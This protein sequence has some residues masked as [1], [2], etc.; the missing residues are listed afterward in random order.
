MATTNLYA[1]KEMTKEIAKIMPPTDSGCAGIAIH[2]F[3]EN[4]IWYERTFRNGVKSIEVDDLSNVP[5]GVYSFADP[6]VYAEW[7][8]EFDKKVDSCKNVTEVYM[9]WRDPWKLT[10]MKFCGEFLGAKQ[11]AE[12]LADAWVTEENP[13]MDVNVSRQEALKMFKGAV[14]KFLMTE[15][16]YEVYKSLPEEFDVYR[17]VACGREPYGLSWTN[18]KE[19]AIWFKNR[20]HREGKECFLL[21]AHINKKDMVAYFNTRNEKEVLLDVFAVKKAGLIERVEE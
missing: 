15:E 14:K 7:R 17:G 18:D 13:N 1:V 21:K 9:L 11:F 8:K 5:T 12:F 6:K 20:W 2:P 16:D 4:M 3:I 19:K 10:F